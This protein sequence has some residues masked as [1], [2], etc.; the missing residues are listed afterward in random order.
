MFAR[1]RE[2]TGFD[3]VSNQTNPPATAHKLFWR[4]NAVRQF[5]EARC[6]LSHKSALCG[7]AKLCISTAPH[8]PGSFLPFETVTIGRVFNFAAV[9]L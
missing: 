8:T 1:Q 5:D 2:L 6:L 9:R 4:L 3:F 7:V